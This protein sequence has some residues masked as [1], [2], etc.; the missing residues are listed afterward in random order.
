MIRLI[1]DF[2]SFIQDMKNN[3]LPD[4]QLMRSLEWLS[5]ETI[6]KWVQNRRVKVEILKVTNKNE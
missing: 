5:N 1:E 6:T 4:V 3:P 2:A